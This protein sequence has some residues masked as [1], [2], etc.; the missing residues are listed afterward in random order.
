MKSLE[1]IRRFIKS[2]AFFELAAKEIISIFPIEVQNHLYYGKTFF[3][4]V[5]FLKESEYWDKERFETF[6]FEQVKALLVH[7]ARHVGYYRELFV[8]YGFNPLTMQSLSDIKTLPYL[9]KETVRDRRNDFLAEDVPQKGLIMTTIG[10]STGIPLAIYKTRENKEIEHA[11]LLNLLTRVGYNPKKKIVSFQLGDITRRGKKKTFLRYGNNLVLSA[12]S[13]TSTQTNHSYYKMITT[14]RPEFVSGFKTVLLSFA[15]FMKKQGLLPLTGLKAALVY[16]E[17]IHP[18]QREI[19]EESFGA[20]VFSV[21]GMHESVVFGGECE[22]S[23]KTHLYP[24][25]GITELIDQRHAHWEIVG[26]GFSNYAMPLIRYRTMDF[27]TKGEH[28]CNQCSRN[29]LLFEE[30]HGRMN[31]FLITQDGK[32]LNTYMSNIASDIFR[33]VKQFQFYQEEL[34]IAY[35]KIV[36][37]PAYAETDNHLIKREVD[38]RFNIPNN[39][40]SITVIFVDNIEQPPSGKTLMTDQRLDIKDFI[41]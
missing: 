37:G 35:L 18:W 15:F 16:G 3:H 29:F 11:S 9:T 13:I 26:T 1:I 21:Y 36:K 33:N 34:G 7:A 19:I 28:R 41:D 32:M 6:Q 17:M 8:E 40:I 14:F 30:I 2:N 5:A 27:C 20:R 31:E 25:I 23:Y 39:R 22:H 12:T 24:Q 10:G 4:W 38:K